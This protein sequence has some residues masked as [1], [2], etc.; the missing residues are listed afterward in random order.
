MDLSYNQNVVFLAGCTGSQ[1][2]SSTK[3]VIRACA[4]NKKLSQICT[5]VF[6]RDD[7]RDITAIH[8][9][10]NSDVIASGGF[11]HLYLLQFNKQGFTPLYV[12]NNIHS[13][14]I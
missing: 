7:M 8:R 11:Q 3:G 1:P 12:F 6:D 2:N 10:H 5:Y 13:G 14:K 4:F 9:L